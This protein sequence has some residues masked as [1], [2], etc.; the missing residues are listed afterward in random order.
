MKPVAVP[1]PKIG[2]FYSGDCY[3]VFYSYRENGGHGKLVQIV[4]YWI[5]SSACLSLKFLSKNSILVK[6]DMIIKIALVIHPLV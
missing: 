1:A 6:I 3:I 5:V 2:Q 4:Y